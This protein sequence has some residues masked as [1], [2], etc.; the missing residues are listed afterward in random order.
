[1]K[2]RSVLVS[3]FT[4]VF[5]LTMAGIARADPIDGSGSASDWD[6][7]HTLCVGCTVDVGNVVGVWQSILYA[8]NLLAKCGS[9]GIDG[10]FGS[11]TANATADWQTSNGLTT[12]GI[13]RTNTWHKA[14]GFVDHRGS[15]YYYIGVGDV[16]EIPF[17]IVSG[18]YN[19]K[20]PSDTSWRGTGHPSITFTTC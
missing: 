5:L 7:N 3:A 9:A 18:N 6:D 4:V 13:V 16:I 12:D 8:D 14:R 17:K 20:S 1:M 2:H 10:H 15:L 11:I 19:F